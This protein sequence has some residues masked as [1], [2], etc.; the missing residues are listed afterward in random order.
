MSDHRGSS[1]QPRLSDAAGPLNDQQ[2]AIGTAGLL[3]RGLDR[4]DLNA[5]FEQRRVGQRAP[6]RRGRS[7]GVNVALGG[8]ASSPCWLHCL[9]L[10]LGEPRQNR[11]PSAIEMRGTLWCL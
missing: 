9:C 3:D 5:T 7:N 4:L 6:M 1:Q 11:S 2:L 8:V 10:E